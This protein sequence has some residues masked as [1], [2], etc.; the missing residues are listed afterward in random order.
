MT[1]EIKGNVLVLDGEP[2]VL[3][4]LTRLLEA[5]QYRVSSCRTGKEALVLFKEKDFDLLII[6]WRLDGRDGLDGFQVMESCSRLDPT[7]AMVVLTA[8]PDVDSAV[9][10]MRLGAKDYLKKPPIPDQLLAL[11]GKVIEE[12][13]ALR[14]R[15]ECKA[16][17]EELEAED[18]LLP[19][20]PG[21]PGPDRRRRNQG[22]GGQGLH[23]RPPGQKA[24]ATEGGGLPGSDPEVYGKRADRSR[25]QP[26]RDGSKAD[27]TF[28]SKTSLR[29]PGS[30]TPKK[31]GKKVL[32]PS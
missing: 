3:E 12:R 30:N 14:C 27:R 23:H 11:V 22:D 17:F 24:G 10:A 6:E 15:R 9:K 32:N 31:P 21:G 4:D 16:V 2:Q 19:E 20:S 26:E 1:A 28:T 29:I 25:A 7:L 18:L 8:F 5:D 13:K